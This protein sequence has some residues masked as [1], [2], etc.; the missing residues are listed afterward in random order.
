MGRK[1]ASGAERKGGGGDPTWGEQGKATVY[2]RAYKATLHGMGSR[3]GK[4]RDI[5]LPSPLAPRLSPF[6]LDIAARPPQ[7]SKTFRQP[8]PHSLQKK[9]KAIFLELKDW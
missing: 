8:L 9:K 3:A 7:L 6:S 2:P 4:Y 1:A 5:A